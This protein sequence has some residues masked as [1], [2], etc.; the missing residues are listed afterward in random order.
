MSTP[1]NDLAA[2]ARTPRAAP[3][4]RIDPRR[5][6]KVLVVSDNADDVRQI[7]R[8][9]ENDHERVQGAQDVE[10]TFEAF[11]ALLPQVVVLAFDQIQKSDQL[12]LGLYR[13][14]AAASTHVH[15]TILLCGQHEAR[16]AYELCKKDCYDDYVLYWPMAQDGMRLS[17]SVWNAAREVAAQLA[18]P[19]DKQLIAY[20]DQVRGAETFFAHEAV[21]AERL[22]R[23]VTSAMAKVE[24]A[25]DEALDSLEQDG[26]R[27]AFHEGRAAFG[28]A[29]S[30]PLQAT[31]RLESIASQA[32]ALASGVARPKATV[33]VVE[34]D[35]LQHDLIGAALNGRG[36]DLVMLSDGASLVGAIRRRKPD[37]ILMD[38]NLPD[39]SGLALT[40]MAKALPRLAGVPVLMLTADASRDALAKS[41]EAGAVGYIVKPFTRATQ[42]KNIE[43]FLPAAAT[44]AP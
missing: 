2:P 43:R 12:L 11:E 26:V 17:M 9:L 19:N 38:I 24:S 1:P 30:W 27:Q 40:R 18:R 41:I 6:S 32:R 29:A 8:R 21:E 16:A 3:S 34:D 5:A 35:P 31:R 4:A 28:E 33:M 10:Q 39:L 25:L 20:A 42:L 13:R 37:L 14:S 23:T 7:I 44:P 22:S 36:I 15:R